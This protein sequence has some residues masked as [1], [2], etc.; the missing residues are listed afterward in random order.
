MLLSETSRLIAAMNITSPSL[1]RASELTDRT[2]IRGAA[3]TMMRR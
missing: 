3:K 1:R 2:K